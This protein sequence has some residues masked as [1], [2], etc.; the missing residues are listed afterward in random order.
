M[1]IHFLLIIFSITAISVS[2]AANVLEKALKAS[3]PNGYS[4]KTI[5]LT[6]SEKDIIEASAKALLN[7]QIITVYQGKNN[8]GTDNYAILANANVRTHPVV[9]LGI[10]DN[11]GTIISVYI[12]AFL[13]PRDYLPTESWINLLPGISKSEQLFPGSS[14]ANITEATLT[15]RTITR[16]LRL[17]LEVIQLKFNLR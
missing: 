1:R 14:I 6:N 17:M 16:E 9:F 3:F 5:M 15:A 13:E 12:I 4:E 8:N 10:I 11:E 2:A 7:S